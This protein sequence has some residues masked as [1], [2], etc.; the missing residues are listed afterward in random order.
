MD[1]TLVRDLIDNLSTEELSFAARTVFY[2][3]LFMDSVLL[4]LE[5]GRKF[6]EREFENRFIEETKTYYVSESTGFMASNSIS[7]YMTRVRYDQL[8][9]KHP[10]DNSIIH[11][12]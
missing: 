4:S 5:D 11:Q 3:V 12:G 6:Y 9:V 7:D 8:K 1:K 2:D 10:S